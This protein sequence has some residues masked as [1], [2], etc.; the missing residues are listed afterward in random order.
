MAKA[1]SRKHATHKK[2]RAHHAA[3]THAR[4]SSVSAKSSSSAGA[5]GPA[6]IKEVEII[7]DE[8]TLRADSSRIPDEDLD[9]EAGIYGASRGEDAGEAT[10]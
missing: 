8:S 9:D 2:A 6:E 3:K 4:R 5:A 10:S 1:T 7:D